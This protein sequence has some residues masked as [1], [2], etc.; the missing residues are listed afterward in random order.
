MRLKTLDA[1]H[2]CST[3]TTAAAFVSSV[4][5]HFHAGG[6]S[7]NLMRAWPPASPAGAAK[8]R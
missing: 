4:S 8:K 5:H 3:N 2:S 6:D 1:E 7:H